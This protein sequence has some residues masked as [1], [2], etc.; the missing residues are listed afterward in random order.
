MFA[1]G[2]RSAQQ[3]ASWLASCAVRLPAE[4]TTST[5]HLASSTGAFW[6]PAVMRILSL[7]CLHLALARHSRS[8]HGWRVVPSG[9]L[10]NAQQHCA[11]C[12]VTRRILVAGCHADFSFGM[13]ALDSRSAQQVASWLVSSAVRR[14]LQNAQRALCNLHRHQAHSGH[15]FRA[16]FSFG[17]SYQAQDPPVSQQCTRA[18]AE[19]AVPACKNMGTCL[20]HACSLKCRSVK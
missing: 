18:R 8:H 16:D 12:I 5:V 2:S 9:F 17:M 10:Q 3:V 1:L 13:F 20:L 15:L 19:L 11:P 6:S 7:A 4:C 14:F